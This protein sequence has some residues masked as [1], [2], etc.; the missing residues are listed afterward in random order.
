MVA[1]K[2]TIY[3][4][5][6]AEFHIELKLVG[7]GLMRA[8]RKKKQMAFFSEFITAAIQNSFL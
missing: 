5:S 4:W 6:E 7:L 8:E 2:L 3:K 1:F